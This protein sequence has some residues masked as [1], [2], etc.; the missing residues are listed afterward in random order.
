VTQTAA[1]WQLRL[2]P[3]AWQHHALK[4]WAAQS[5]GVV[6]V[7]TG[8]GKTAFAEMCMLS[9]LHQHSDGRFLILVP[10]A[11]LLDQWYVSLQEDLGVAP[12]EI[13]VYSGQGR[14]SAPSRVNLMVINTGRDW[15]AKIASSGTNCLIVD[16]CHRAGSPVNRLAL[17]GHYAGALGMSATPVRDYD[18]WFEE[19]VAPA[20]G[21]V[22]FEYDYRT[23]RADGVVVPFDLVNVR[24]EMLQSERRDYD[25]LSQMVAR[26]LRKNPGKTTDDDRLKRLLLQRAAVSAKAAMRV[27]VAVKLVERHKGTRTIVFHERIDAANAI[28]GL[29]H[30]RGVSAAVYHTRIGESVRRE[31]LRLFRRGLFECLV[32]CRALDEGT[33]VPETSVAIIASSTSSTRQRIQRLGRVL[34]PARGKHEALVYTL[35]ATTTEESRLRTEA[36]KMEE[37]SRVQW[38]QGRVP[39]HGED[40]N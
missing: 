12:G 16:E 9:F 19:F 34:R 33:N 1:A 7:V 37:V 23:A 39:G 30:E 17:R 22:I 21:P 15:A 32:T 8:A 5:R 2:E 14:P 20:L 10:G 25:R 11:A 29:L 24:V 3:R 6:S 4:K 31:N 40:S 28:L 18:T 13:A 27:P 36:A 35:Y 38:L 26:H